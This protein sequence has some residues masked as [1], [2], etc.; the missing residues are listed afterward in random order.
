[1]LRFQFVGIL[2]LGVSLAALGLPGVG[3]AAGEDFRIDNTVYSADAKAPPIESTTI[4]HNGVVYDCMKTPNETVVFDRT[5]G[6]FVLLNLKSRTRAE[7]TTGELAAFIDRLQQVAAKTS[8]PVVKFL[9]APKFQEQFDE[10]TGELKLSSTW[11]NYRVV[12][13]PEEDSAAVQQYREFSDWYARLN[14][15]LSP[16]SRLPLA[17]LAVNAAL[18]R[19]K[20]MPSEVVLTISSSKQNRQPITIRSTHRVVRP[21]TPA[22]LDRVAKAREHLTGFK[23][24][25]FEQYRKADVW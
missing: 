15:L 18:A 21:L 16:G 5:G 23:L 10:A 24:V 11:V 3:S 14:T 22:D 19:R 8:E 1:M 20:A 17:R 2:A 7:L 4:F 9:A 12:S 13:S 25:S 6:R